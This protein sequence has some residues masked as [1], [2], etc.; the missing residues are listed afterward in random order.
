LQCLDVEHHQNHKCEPERIHLVKSIGRRP[1]AAHR[2]GII[3]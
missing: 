1:A 3:E 2:V